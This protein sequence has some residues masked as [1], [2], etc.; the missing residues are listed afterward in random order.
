MSQSLYPAKKPCTCCGSEIYWD[1]TIRE[2]YNIKGPLNMDSSP[3]KCEQF[4][5]VKQQEQQLQWL[6]NIEHE[7][8]REQEPNYVLMKL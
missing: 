3:H 5:K 1:Q 7:R 6:N 2:T 4:K 8:Q